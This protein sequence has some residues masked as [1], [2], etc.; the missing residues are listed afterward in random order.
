[1]M[2]EA[3]WRPFEQEIAYRV[4][5]EGAV[6]PRTGVWIRD[7]LVLVEEDYV[8]NMYSLYREFARSVPYNPGSY[9]TFR[10]YLFV[11]RDLGLIREVRQEESEI[12]AIDKKPRIYYSVVQEELYN[13]A[14][15][16]P[17]REYR[18][19]LAERAEI[20]KTSASAIR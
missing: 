16:H 9:Q 8:W 17:Y 20:K 15:E 18:L 4:R 6:V 13:P 3:D 7:H 14:W 12:V 19:V 5:D 2:E 10:T 1:M 11:C